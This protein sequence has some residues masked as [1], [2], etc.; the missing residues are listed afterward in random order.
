M[1]YAVNKNDEHYIGNAGNKI[2]YNVIYEN[3]NDYYKHRELIHINDDGHID[4][5]NRYIIAKEGINDD[6]VICK[7]QLNQLD[8]NLKEYT[9]NKISALQNSIN[10]S[11]QNLI[12]AH[13]AKILTQM[14]NFRNEQIKDRIRRKFLNIPKQPNKEHILLHY[15]EIDGEKDLRNI[16]ILNVWISRYEAFHHSKSSDVEL[17]FG[18]SL[19]HFYNKSMTTFSIYF[20]KYPSNWDLDCFVKYLRIPKEISINDENI[21][22]PEHENNNNYV[23]E[24]KIVNN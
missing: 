4:T 3:T 11:I 20:T 17:A 5:E 15:N 22:I 7:K 23:P 21:S 2:Q 19:E 9:D 1:Y 18:N 10:S 8:T 14:L 24:I 16:V 13:E 6:H 12:K